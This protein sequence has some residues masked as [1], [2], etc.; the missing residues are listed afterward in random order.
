MK[1]IK[2]LACVLGAMLLMVGVSSCRNGKSVKD[3]ETVETVVD[4]TEVVAADSV[5][6]VDTLAE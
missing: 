6:V 5:A 2:T 3:V 1:T 4:S